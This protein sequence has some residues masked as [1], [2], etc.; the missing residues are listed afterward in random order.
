QRGNNSRTAHADV[1]SC[2]AVGLG[3]LLVETA[4]TKILN[5]RCS[6]CREEQGTAP[7]APGSLSEP[8]SV[9]GLRRT[10]LSPDI[11]RPRPGREQQRP[12]R[13]HVALPGPNRAGTIRTVAEP[14]SLGQS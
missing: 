14:N 5:K 11:K 7:R 1:A 9:L 6:R 2:S 12:A 13:S 8:G 4:A 3:H 10:I